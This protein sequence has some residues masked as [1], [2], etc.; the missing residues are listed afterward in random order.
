MK[1][2]VETRSGDWGL[3]KLGED[4]ETHTDSEVILLAYYFFKI[5]KVG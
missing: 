2:A 3:Q 5:R 1:Q 4:T